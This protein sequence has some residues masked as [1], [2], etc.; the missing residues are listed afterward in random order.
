MGLKMDVINKTEKRSEGMDRKKRLKM[1]THQRLQYHN[2][3]HIKRIKKGTIMAKTIKVMEVGCP[4][5]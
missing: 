2:A 5:N 1:K 3:R 4:G